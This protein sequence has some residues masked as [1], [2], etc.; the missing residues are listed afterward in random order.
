M[1]TVVAWMGTGGTIAALVLVQELIIAIKLG[2]QAV[3]EERPQI[4]HRNLNFQRLS[5][6]QVMKRISLPEM[7]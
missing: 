2:G 4:L 3:V 5:V 7:L 6:T 1:H